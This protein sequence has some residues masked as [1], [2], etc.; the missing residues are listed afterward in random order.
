[1]KP[2]T[3]LQ[4]RVAYLSER[5][6]RI[7]QDQKSWAYKVCITHQAFANKSSANCMDCGHNIALESIN[8]NRATCT[9]C[10]TKLKVETTL[11]RKY[12]Q[13]NY[14]AICEIVEEFQVIRNFEIKSRHKKGFSVD[15]HTM[16]ILEYWIKEDGKLTMIGRNHNC[17]GYCDSWGGDWAI[18]KER[19]WYK[20][21][22]VYPRFYHPKSKFR[23]EYRKFGVDYRL[24][25]INLLEAIKLIPNN[26]MAETLLKLRKYNLLASYDENNS[27]VRMYWRSIKIAIRHKYKIKDT[28]IWFDY[29]DL[30][31]YFR[32]DLFNPVYICPKN[33]KKAHD[34]LVFKKQQIIAKCN[35]ESR[36]KKALKDQREFK[37]HISKF[38]GL[39]FSN[40]NFKVVVL[41]TVDDFLKEGDLLKHCLFVNEYY[42]KTDS[43]VLSARLNG[44]PIETI[45]VS[46]SKMKVIQSRG[47]KNNPTNHHEEIVELVN[48]NLDKIAKINSAKVKVKSLKN[49]TYVQAV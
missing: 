45:E 36:K 6:P 5:L 9:N 33:L 41:E 26:P 10:G 21:Y 40:S 34:R 38:K 25:G 22:D 23:K 37:K 49:R 14:F 29:L 39:I 43:L 32:K 2:K 17:Q 4:K 28:G 11:K 47:L 46:L 31:A 19:S 35:E 7:T 30:L 8:R 44:Q 42:T 12:N 13:T 48:A 18:R 1:M 3:K 20:K 27:N 24:S 16:E 15:Y